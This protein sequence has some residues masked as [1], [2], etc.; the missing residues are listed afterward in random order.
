MAKLTSFE[1]ICSAFHQPIES[2][3]GLALV[4]AHLHL[5]WVPLFAYLDDMLIV[6]CSAHEVYNSVRLCI[7]HQMQA[8]YILNLKKSDLTPT[9]D[10]I[11]I[12]G[13][14]RT[15]LGLVFLLPPR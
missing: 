4:I 12:G 8:W 14:F 5:Q 6:G 7:L 13:C 10:L 3:P 11:Y 1:H 2:S 15:Y 9:Q